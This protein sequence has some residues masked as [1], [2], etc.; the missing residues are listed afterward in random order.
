MSFSYR[1]GFCKN[2]LAK[3]TWKCRRESY[4]FI[5]SC[6]DFPSPLCGGNL[7]CPYLEPGRW[8]QRLVGLGSTGFFQAGL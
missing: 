4:L 6:L 5:S 8:G 3:D 7:L 1:L 2:E